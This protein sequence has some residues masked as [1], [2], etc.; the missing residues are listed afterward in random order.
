MTVK[1]ILLATTGVSL[2]QFGRAEE[3]HEKNVWYLPGGNGNSFTCICCERPKE[4]FAPPEPSAHFDN[5]SSF[6][7][8]SRFD[9]SGYDVKDPAG[10]LFLRWE[11]IR[12]K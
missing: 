4:F 9:H 8:C 1:K 10:C 2:L 3:T 5:A 6:A 12:W 11:I 7:G